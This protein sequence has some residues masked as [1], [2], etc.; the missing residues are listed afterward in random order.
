MIDKLHEYGMSISY[1][2]V[3]DI[4]TELGEAVV[5]QYVEDGVVCPP[6]MRKRL[7][8]T[9]AVDNT[10]HNPTS[11]TASSS[12]HGT[13]ISLFQHPSEENNGEEHPRLNVQPI[14]FYSPS[15]NGSRQ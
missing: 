12:F 11:T 13:S 5:R 3:L 2:R 8:T 14:E 10:D 1:A 6:S 4:S 7:F 9:A 15:S